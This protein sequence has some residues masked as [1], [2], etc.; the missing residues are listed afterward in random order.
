[1]KVQ[2]IFHYIDSL[3]QLFNESKTVNFEKWP[4]LGVWVWNNKY[5]YQT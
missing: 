4:V 1:L 5:V 2:S 3:V